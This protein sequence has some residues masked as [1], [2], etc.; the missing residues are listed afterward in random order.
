VRVVGHA[1]WAVDALEQPGAG[2][3]PLEV[4]GQELHAAITVQ[5]RTGRRLGRRSAAA[6]TRRVS[7]AVRSVPSLLESMA[8]LAWGGLIPPCPCL[9]SRT[10]VKGRWVVP[11]PCP[12]DR[13]RGIGSHQKAVPAAPG[14]IIRPRGR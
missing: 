2:Q 1:V 5:Q 11:A 7:W 13:W 9:E 4:A 8:C 10:S 12:S 6:S 3:Y 14:S